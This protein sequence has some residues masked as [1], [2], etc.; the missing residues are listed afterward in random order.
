MP[1]N[2]HRSVA[3]RA[4]GPP[5]AQWSCEARGLHATLDRPL[6]SSKA[7]VSPNGHPG[8]VKIT[9]QNQMSGERS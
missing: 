4:R 3:R 8:M 1:S 7:A 2:L 6:A 9:F 5:G